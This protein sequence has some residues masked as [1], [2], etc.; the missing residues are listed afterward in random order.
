MSQLLTLEIYPRSSSISSYHA[1]GFNETLSF[2]ITAYCF[3]LC[4][5]CLLC[6][7]KFGAFFY[8]AKSCGACSCC[9]SCRRVVV[10][11]CRRVSSVSRE[12]AALCVL[13]CTKISLF[14]P[15]CKKGNFSDRCY[16]TSILNTRSYYTSIL[17]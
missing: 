6:G 10:S 5:C 8:S 2:F 13:R 9:V 16:W 17:K 14:F 12:L 3:C 1:S 11:S 15:G 4:V 7:K